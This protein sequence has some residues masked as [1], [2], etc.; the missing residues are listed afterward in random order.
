M[1]KTILI[2]LSLVALSSSARAATTEQLLQENKALKAELAALRSKLQTHKTKTANNSPATGQSSALPNIKGEPVASVAVPPWQGFYAG[3]NAG[4]GWGT[5]SNTTSSLW[6]AGSGASLLDGEENYSQPS[7]LAGTVG[8]MRQSMTQ[9]GFI[10]GAQFGYNYR[11]DQHF[12]FG[13]ETDIQGSG[14]R[15]GSTALGVYAGNGSDV[16]R[17]PTTRQLI[18]GYTGTVNQTGYGMAAVS[19]GL[20]YLGTA[21]LRVGYLFT[22]NILIYGTGGL[23]YGGAWANVSGAGASTINS[24]IISNDPVTSAI[25]C[26][27]ACTAVEQPWNAGSRANALL[28]GYSA[29]GG[30]EWIFMQN[31][32]LKGEAIYYNI[33][34]M[35]I[36]TTTIAAPA[37]GRYPASTNPG[38]TFAGPSVIGGNTS[39]NYQGVI[40]RLGVNYHVTFGTAP[41]VASY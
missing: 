3:L 15:G 4:Y 1:K 36:A 29:G 30:L 18:D 23:A 28:V 16:V 25:E 34:N 10:G 19:A 37:Y 20:D 27:S 24:D 5:N 26:P 2:A 17:E 13:F 22:P 31:W 35:N 39:V 8:A 12:V 14:M 11:H 40:A 32:S 7:F 6:S 21:R 38:Q 41:V 33:G 9:S